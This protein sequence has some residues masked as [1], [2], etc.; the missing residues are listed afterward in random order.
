MFGRNEAYGRSA[1]EL[2]WTRILGWAMSEGDLFS[3]KM[4][5]TTTYSTAMRWIVAKT[6]PDDH[7]YTIGVH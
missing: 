5:I 6:Q 1:N 3:C 2:E 4:V 7:C